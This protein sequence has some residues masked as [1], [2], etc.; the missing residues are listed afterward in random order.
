MSN[1]SD[2]N[3]K[4]SEDQSIS[5]EEALAA[6]RQK[7][8]QRNKSS[9]A[10]GGQIPSNNFSLAPKG[11]SLLSQSNR[12]RGR[13]TAAYWIHNL[14]DSI[15]QG[16]Q[17]RFESIQSDPGA[18]NQIHRRDFIPSQRFIIPDGIAQEILSPEQ[19][20]QGSVVTSVDLHNA[21]QTGVIEPTGRIADMSGGLN[22]NPEQLEQV[23]QK[24]RQEQK[25]RPGYTPPPGTSNLLDRFGLSGNEAIEDFVFEEV[26]LNRKEQ[27]LPRKALK[28]NPSIRKMFDPKH[29]EE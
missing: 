7:K 22:L 26:T 17:A 14:Q 29:A 8:A 21:Q 4:K 6:I 25:Q 11:G 23:A 27:K 19:L 5:V 20:R 13:P 18:K 1:T 15:Q 28:I 12:R 2:N 16:L 9:E 10:K 3:E 24:V